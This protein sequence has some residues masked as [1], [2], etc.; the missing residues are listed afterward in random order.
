MIF[1]GLSRAWEKL[2][3]TVSWLIPLAPQLPHLPLVVDSFQ[4]VSKAFYFPLHF[5]RKEGVFPSV[6]PAQFL[7]RTACATSAVIGSSFWHIVAMTCFF[8]SVRVSV[9]STCDKNLHKVVET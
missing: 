2:V 1:V 7:S 9:F 3:L 8:A 5:F 4:P 6:T